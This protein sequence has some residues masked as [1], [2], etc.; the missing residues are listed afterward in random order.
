RDAEHYAETL[1]EQRSQAAAAEE[2]SRGIA[3]ELQRLQAEHED[4]TV[5]LARQNGDVTEA[6]DRI[7]QLAYSIAEIDRLAANAQ[8]Q[9]AQEE[10][11]IAEATARLNAARDASDALGAELVEL[12]RSAAGAR[13]QRAAIEVQRAEALARLNFVRESCA[14]ELNPPLKHL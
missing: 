10:R 1:N 5:R 9:K 2:R 11:Q 8:E 13:D 7:E 3:S 6:G 14:A 12:N 4:T